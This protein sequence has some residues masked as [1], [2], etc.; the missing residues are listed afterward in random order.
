[1]N[2]TTFAYEQLIERFVA[3]AQTRPDICAAVVLGSRARVDGPADEWSDL[4]IVILVTDPKPYLTG[5]DWLKNI[6]N[7]WIT[8]VEPTAIGGEMEHRVLFEGG[9][10]VD[11][12]IIPY[13]KVEQMIHHGFPPEVA[14]VFRRG[15]RVLLDR[16]DLAARLN[17]LST[18]RAPAS[19][20]TQSEFLEAINDFWYH[21]VWTAKKLRRGELWTATT[22]CDGYMKHLLLKG[23]EW[24]AQVLNGPDYDTWHDGRFLE[25]WAD[26]RALERLRS[27]FA[28]YDED[29]IEHA[30]VATM[31][32]F[33]WLARE[34]AEGLGF[35]YPAYA[36]ERATE[37]VNTFL[38]G[39][40]RTEITDGA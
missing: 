33:R 21:A 13:A 6:G 15:R 19:S 3:W 28:H 2:Q 26:R 38:S 27:A 36:D 23:M 16:A 12:S 20:P 4:D 34:T 18:E 8:S 24:H 1:M 9:L 30:L 40:T 10:D 32:L 31:D 39:R 25:R 14:E 17:Q 5:A 7:Y 22:C 35:P 11:F 37:L 29:D